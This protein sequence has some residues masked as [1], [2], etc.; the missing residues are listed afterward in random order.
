MY[1]IQLRFCLS[2][3][4]HWMREQV[5]T[6]VPADLALCEF[7]C[8]QTACSSEEWTTCQRRISWRPE[9]SCLSSGRITQTWVGTL[10]A[11]G[12]WWVQHDWSIR[13]HSCGP[14]H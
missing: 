12:N 11:I 7:D 2:R 4:G 14:E 1:L 6:E 3:L 5:V 8:Q 9:N 13:P 10:K